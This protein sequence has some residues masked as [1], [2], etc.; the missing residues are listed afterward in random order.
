MGV[1]SLT[2]KQVRTTA[3]GKTRKMC[4]M[5]E[6]QAIN[7]FIKNGSTVA[8]KKVI[9]DDFNSLALSWF[10]SYKLTVKIN[11][12]RVANNFLQV[13]ILPALRYNIVNCNFCCSTRRGWNCQNR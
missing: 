4:E 2:G 13:Y 5:K 12:I 9:F 8:R 7:K 6:N 11:T 1:D 10:E 3:T